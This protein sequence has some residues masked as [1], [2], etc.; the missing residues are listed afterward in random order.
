M[1]HLKILFGCQTPFCF[2]L[3]QV[4]KGHD[5]RNYSAA[6]PFHSCSWEAASANDWQWWK[7]LSLCC[8]LVFCKLQMPSVKMHPI[9]SIGLLS[10]LSGFTSL[11]PAWCLWESPHEWMS[12]FPGLG[13][14]AAT[15][16]EHSQRALTN[17]W[18]LSKQPWKQ[19]K[20]HFAS[21]LLQLPLPRAMCS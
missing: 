7:R 8:F 20:Q 13:K 3:G 4:G 17:L 1:W 19:R 5:S 12:C 11:L 16:R 9:I 18:A 15:Q 6:S 14:N 2:L 21:S 10:S